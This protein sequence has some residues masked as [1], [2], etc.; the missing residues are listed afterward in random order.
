MHRARTGTISLGGKVVRLANPADA[1]VRGMVLV[2]RDRRNDGLVLDMNVSENIN[3]ASLEEVSRF[4]IEMRGLANIRAVEQ[5]EELDIRPDNPA[6]V[7]RLLSGGNQ[8]KTVLARWLA[9]DA[10]VFLLDEPTV[11]VDVGA[12]VEIYQLIENLAQNG[13]A[14][15]LSSSDPGELIG[16]CDRIY[17]MMRG[18][19]THEVDARGLNIDQFVAMTTGAT[20]QNSMGSATHAR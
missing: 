3:L 4:G 2:P 14:I 18:R 19:I 8:Q 15:L 10:K 1:V 17:V 20:A 5:I 13:A 11:G 12:K 6:M 16:L 9:T 7:S